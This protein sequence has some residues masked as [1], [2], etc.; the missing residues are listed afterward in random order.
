MN[1]KF[2]FFFLSI[3]SGIDIFIHREKK[4]FYDRNERSN[5][6]IREFCD[7]DLYWK[8]LQSDCRFD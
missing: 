2:L 4:N 3:K 8:K 7:N 6:L 5:K 1:V